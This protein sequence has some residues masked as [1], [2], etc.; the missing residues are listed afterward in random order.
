VLFRSV[1]A[2]KGKNDKG[3]VVKWR[4]TGETGMYRYDLE[5]VF[6]IIVVDKQSDKGRM[7]TF[8]ITGDEVTVSVAPGIVPESAV[9]D[10]K[11]GQEADQQ[12]PPPLRRA[13]YGLKC[14]VLP[15]LSLSTVTTASA[16]QEVQSR[17][18]YA[19]EVGT[20]V[21]D[22]ALVQ[23]A[24]R[25]L[26]VDS[27]LRTPWR[28]VLSTAEAEG[29]YPDSTSPLLADLMITPVLPS[30][31][32]DALLMCE[33]PD[34]DSENDVAKTD[35]WAYGLR[36]RVNREGN[37]VRVG[38]D[39]GSLGTL[40]CGQAR[41]IPGTNGFCGPSNGANCSACKELQLRRPPICGDSGCPL[42]VSDY[43]LNGY[44]TG[45]SCNGCSKST[46]RSN[47]GRV[48]WFCER[49]HYDLCFECHPETPEPAPE[50]ASRAPAVAPIQIPTE[51]IALTAAGDIR[52]GGT[53][54]EFLENLLQ[55]G[56][57]PWNKWLH[58]NAMGDPV[59]WVQA[60]FRDH[61]FRVTG[62][63]MCSANDSPER[64]PVAW[65]LMGQQTR[66]GVWVELHSVDFSSGVG[67]F[68]E[69]S[70]WQWLTLDL[71]GPSEPVSAVRFVFEKK[72]RVDCDCLQLGH[73]QLRGLPVKS[74][75][76]GARSAGSGVPVPLGGCRPEEAR[77]GVLRA[78]N[79][80]VSSS[81]QMLD[82]SLSLTQS[83]ADSE[84]TKEPLENS[85]VALLSRVRG[86]IFAAV[87]K[88]LLDRALRLSLCVSK[89]A[90]SP[91]PL[92]LSRVRARQA[93]QVLGQTLFEQAMRVLHYLPTENL[94]LGDGSALFTPEL[95]DTEREDNASDGLEMYKRCLLWFAQELM[96]SALPLLV[97]LPQT[98]TSATKPAAGKD[99]SGSQLWALNP[100]ATDAVHLD[101]YCF[102]GKLL[103]VCLRTNIAFPV[104]LAPAVW[105][106]LVGEGLVAGSSEVTSLAPR[107]LSAVARLR[108]LVSGGSASITEEQFSS[109][110]SETFTVT[111]L[112]GRIV[113]LVPDGA[114]IR[115]SWSRLQE[116]CQL[117][118]EYR[119]HEMDVQAKAVRSG[120]STVV[121]AAPLCL[122]TGKQLRALVHGEGLLPIDISAELRWIVKVVF[123]EGAKVRQGLELSSEVIH[124]VDFCSTI[125]VF[126]RR[127][128]RENIPR[129][130]TAKGWMSEM[131]N[132]AAGSVGAVAELVP[133]RR[134]LR[135]RVTAA[136]AVF[137]R[138]DKSSTQ[139][140]QL[141]VEETVDVAG[142]LFSADNERWV[143]LVDVPGGQSGNAA[144]GGFVWWGSAL[145]DVTALTVVGLAPTATE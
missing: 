84:A 134:P 136:A 81:L 99:S 62:Y 107:H 57:E 77:F 113:E 98:Q 120:L 127:V 89:S 95:D 41:P 140:R 10:D 135:F 59:S 56:T 9:S 20:V 38:T 125:E 76:H 60:D 117:S 118:E 43:S 48:R 42:V 108:N 58:P 26:K 13:C 51:C 123:N 115:V 21:Q 46:S 79:K 93:G 53:G 109:Q 92:R 19:F 90:Q 143:R 44:T 144:A 18:R 86:L 103:G 87:K 105:R 137:E 70:R 54:R 88:P 52:G 55:T 122:F 142:K 111:S 8:D 37:E 126:E 132:P 7:L 31:S 16:Y 145:G 78:L 5:G 24:D 74:L 66:D 40:Y 69:T 133:M 129:L 139:L 80:S 34:T 96:S 39:R 61:S 82:L 112:D 27:A 6:D 130:R 128:N 17:V 75:L 12:A 131:L 49:C 72:R 32:A 29:L 68:V 73:L 15:V 63:S 64:D 94:C 102:F 25:F 67:G 23:F 110:F 11:A 85:T 30:T 45:F 1:K 28:D 114:S 83:A 119:V 121:P 3:A 33:D 138:P 124:S 47:I 106:L 35:L 91:V 71:P 101:M 100:S 97:P 36:Q 116:Y 104:K 14:T 22:T 141:E 4:Q 2:W 50:S 65:S